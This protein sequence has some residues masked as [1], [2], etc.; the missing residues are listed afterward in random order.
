ME[1]GQTRS[2]ASQLLE[3][4]GE[5]GK[6]RGVGNGDTGAASS[7]S[8][9]EKHPRTLRCKWKRKKG[10]QGREMNVRAEISNV[11]EDG[12]WSRILRLKGGMDE[13]KNSREKEEVGVWFGT[14]MLRS[15][16]IGRSIHVRS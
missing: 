13:K 8:A 15:G 5:S 14:V 10:G 3:F 6:R 7:L 4:W 11:N 16:V 12:N 9:G 2:E 1:K